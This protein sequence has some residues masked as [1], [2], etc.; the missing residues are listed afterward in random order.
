[1]NPTVLAGNYLQRLQNLLEQFDYPSFQK[2]VDLL[3]EAWQHQRQ[4][5]TL[6]NGGSGATA[7]HLVCD[8]N[9][10]CCFDLPKKFKVMCLND[11][12]PSLLA[13]ANDVSFEAVF[14]GQLQNF[15]AP[16]DVVMAFSG[17]GNSP[18]VIRAI[19]YARKHGAKTIGLTG[20]D[21]GRLAPLVDVALVIPSDDMQQIED[22]H[23]IV[24]HMLMQ[25]CYTALRHPSECQE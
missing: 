8:L 14:E 17:S 1:M 4:I 15:L 23:L 13:L 3:V 18:N 21:G 24:A 9:K 5:F 11:N 7:S 10:G 19:R 2:T 22:V 20:Y 6:G 16:Q 25:I 12:I